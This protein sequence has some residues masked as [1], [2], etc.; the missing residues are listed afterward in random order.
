[1]L[2]GTL[3]ARTRADREYLLMLVAI[4]GTTISPYLFFRQ[5][6]EGEEEIARGRVTVEERRGASPRAMRAAAVDVVTGMSFSAPIFYFVVLT[7]GAP[8]AVE[9][10]CRRAA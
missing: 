1:M 8:C 4:V 6:A 2:H 7:T 3:I 9:V 10:V 5:A